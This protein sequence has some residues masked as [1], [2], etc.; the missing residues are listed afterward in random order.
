MKRNR[1]ALCREDIPSNFF[2]NP[3]LVEKLKESD[4]ETDENACVWFYEGRNGWWQYDMRNSREIE[5]KHNSGVDSTELL[6]AGHL[7]VID[8]RN[9][10]QHRVNNARRI[11]KIKRDLISIPKKGVAGLRKMTKPES[12]PGDCDTDQ[13]ASPIDPSDLQSFHDS[14]AQSVN[15]EVT[16]DDVDA[17]A[18]SLQNVAFSQR[19]PQPSDTL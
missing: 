5:E 16:T 12:E 17:L 10:H 13:L 11:R 4:S 14:E 18:S 15:R 9:M 6:I 7:Y 1:C 3:E 2:N 19:D 8:F